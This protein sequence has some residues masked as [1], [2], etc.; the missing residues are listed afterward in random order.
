MNGFPVA[1]TIVFALLGAAGIILAVSAPGLVGTSDAPALTAIGAAM[2]GGSLAFYLSEMFGWE[3]I[4][5][6]A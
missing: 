3:R 6:R 1:Q 5:S 4:R 2:F